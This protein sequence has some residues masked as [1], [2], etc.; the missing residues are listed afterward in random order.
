MAIAVERPTNRH[1]LRIKYYGK[2]GLRRTCIAWG[3]VGETV[4]IQKNPDSAF[5]AKIGHLRA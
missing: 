1:W 4:K 2:S 5:T 3:K